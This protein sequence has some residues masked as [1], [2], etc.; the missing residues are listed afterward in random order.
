MAARPGAAG[1][2][3]FAHRQCNPKQRQQA[4][5]PTDML[6]AQRTHQAGLAQQ[7]AQAQV[8]ATSGG[9][10]LQGMRAD[11]MS[12]TAAQQLTAQQQQQ[13]YIST[14]HQQQQQS[15]PPSAASTSSRHSAAEGPFTSKHLRALSQQ[16]QQ[17]QQAQ[18]QQHQQHQLTTPSRPGT[19]PALSSLLIAAV[20]TLLAANM[21]ALAPNTG[22]A[23]SV[24]T[25]SPS[26]SPHTR[27]QSAS[28]S[29]VLGTQATSAT[30]SAVFVTADFSESFLG[31]LD[32]DGQ[33]EFSTTSSEDEWSDEQLGRVD[34]FA[35]SQDH[36]EIL[37]LIGRGAFGSVY[38]GAWRGH[39]VAVK[40]SLGIP[41]TCQDFVV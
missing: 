1:H 26:S 18:Q 21:P 17:A 7:P 40:V 15:R 32:F 27:N 8:C 31:Q 41:V 2:G 30:S 33:S 13:Q 14:R 38:R 20:P 3:Q 34:S 23:V 29:Q 9:K 5:E 28:S 19:P 35:A 25:G 16:A 12:S 39:L 24:D 6:E 36:V 4:Q 37:Q 11:S 22:S 10:Q